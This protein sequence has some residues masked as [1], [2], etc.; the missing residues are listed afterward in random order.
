MPEKE[1]L[2]KKDQEQLIWR[3]TNIYFYN[4]IYISLWYTANFHSLIQIFLFF[5][6]LNSTVN[7]HT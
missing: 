2:K 4:L 6:I 7:Y 5:Y 3:F 1:F